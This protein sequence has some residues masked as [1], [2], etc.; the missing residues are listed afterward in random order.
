MSLQRVR[1]GAEINNMP[2]RKNKGMKSAKS[3]SPE[4]ESEPVAGGIDE[5]STHVNLQQQVQESL[6]TDRLELK[7][8]SL[9]RSQIHC[10]SLL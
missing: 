4:R 7:S 5:E 9:N 1:S 3:N 2:P 10:F 6:E 8:Q